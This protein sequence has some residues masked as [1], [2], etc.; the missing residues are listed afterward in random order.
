MNSVAGHSEDKLRELFSGTAARKGMTSAAVEK[1]FWV[2]WVLLRLFEHPALTSQILFKGGTSLS[3]VFH[4]VERF[5]E[6]IDLILDWRLLTTTKPDAD[7]SRTQQD[8]F[9]EKI[10]LKAN[11]Y[12]REDLLPMVKQAVGAYCQ[13]GIDELDSAVIQIRY[14]GVFKDPYLRS[15]IR[16]EIGP[17]AGW[18]PYAEYSIVPYAA[19][20]FPHLFSFAQCKVKAIKAERTFW[21][22]ATILHREAFRSEKSKPQTHYSRHYYDLAR[23]SRSPVK[24]EALKDIELLQMVVEFKRRFYPCGWAKYELAKPGSMRLMPPE[25]VEKVLRDDYEAMRIMVFGE[26]SS[27]DDILQELRSLEGEINSL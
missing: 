8:D 17:L 4:L 10:I 26:Y 2:C 11:D 19:E 22:K 14:P 12:L 15:D 27:F 20:V 13:A 1:D 7:R 18:V 6:D 3:K 16:L 9:N 5:S 25:H 21:E 24:C 23:M